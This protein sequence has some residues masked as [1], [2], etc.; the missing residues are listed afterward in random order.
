GG[1]AGRFDT[2]T[3]DSA[4][5]CSVNDWECVRSTSYIYPNSPITPS[6]AAAYVQAG[7]EIATHVT[8]NC[9][10]FTPQSIQANFD[11][12]LGDFAAN[13][14]GLP[15]PVTNRTHCI[16][17]SDYDTHPQVELSHGIRFDTN[18]YY[19]PPTWVNNI[20]GLF[21]GSGMPMRFATK[22]GT[23]IDVYQATTQMTDES[24]QSYPLN[25]DTLLDNALGI[26]G[27]Y[28]VFTANMHTDSADSD[29]SV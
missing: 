25:I 1:T 19:W 28:G 21:T 17:W 26:K 27:Y 6:Q 20:P 7:F 29:G 9:Q 11:N 14:P 5:G 12:D 22:D 8:T 15:A 23:I 3:A 13:Y 10:D 18:Y 2:Y 16:P 4:P 24:G